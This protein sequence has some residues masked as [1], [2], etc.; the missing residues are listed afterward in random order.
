M[1]GLADL[2]KFGNVAGEVV[3]PMTDESQAARYIIWSIMLRE[4]SLDASTVRNYCNGISAA[5]EALKGALKLPALLNPIRTSRV[6]RMQKVAMNEYKKP[7]KAK[8]HWCCTT[9]ECSVICCI[10]GPQFLPFG[11]DPICF[12]DYVTQL[13]T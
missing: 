5:H 12:H 8:Q 9:D 7:S 1:R 11:I 10:F 4:P 13:V 3:F 6:R 2:E